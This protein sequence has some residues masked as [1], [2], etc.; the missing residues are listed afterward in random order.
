MPVTD[1][2]AQQS[3]R[4]RRALRAPGGGPL[5]TLYCRRARAS[6]SVLNDRPQVESGPGAHCA[7]TTDTDIASCSGPRCSGASRRPLIPTTSAGN[8]SPVGAKWERRVAFRRRC[9]WWRPLLLVE[10]VA[11]GRGRCFWWRPLLPHD[12]AAC[13]R[14]ATTSRG[15]NWIE[16]IFAQP[17]ARADRRAGSPLASARR[18]G[19]QLDKIHLT[20]H[21]S[22]RISNVLT[23]WPFWFCL[24]P[25]ARGARRLERHDG[26]LA[27][28]GGTGTA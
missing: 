9:F 24:G 23:S 20:L 4:R 25:W 16:Q 27:A 22:G 17:P 8:R 11:S 5:L 13:R 12:L 19:T 3:S 18:S 2:P 28:A 6:Q 10:A 15:A 1:S 14:T 26:W 21:C 7:A